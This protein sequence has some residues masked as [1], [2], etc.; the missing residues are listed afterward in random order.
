M[1]LTNQ[2]VSQKPPKPVRDAKHLDRV[3]GMDCVVC[4]RTPCEAHHCRV[5]LRTMGKR[6]SDH[7]VLPLCSE[8][9]ADLHHGFGKEE[10]FWECH[11]IELIRFAAREIVR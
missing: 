2:P 11:L 1:N 9:H 7:Q 5:G 6:V 8:H 3:R 10:L 4:G